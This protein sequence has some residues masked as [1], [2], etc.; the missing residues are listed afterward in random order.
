MYIAG[1]SVQYLCN[2]FAHL[3][4]TTEN[5]T[6]ASQLSSCHT[7][8][9]MKHYYIFKTDYKSGKTIHICNGGHETIFECS[10]HWIIYMYGFMD[11]AYE[12]LGYG[13]FEMDGGKH[14]Q[15]SIRF[16]TKDGSK[17]VEY[18]MLLDKEGQDLINEI[19]K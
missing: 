10:S 17:D 7:N 15:L 13:N 11:A 1:N 18:F 2:D 8:N 5:Q 14:S 16:T 6:I 12:F 3:I 19:S 4:E 9:I